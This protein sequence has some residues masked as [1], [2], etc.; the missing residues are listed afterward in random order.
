MR[1]AYLI[2]LFQ[3]FLKYQ[4]VARFTRNLI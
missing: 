4:M 2:L 3:M 1:H